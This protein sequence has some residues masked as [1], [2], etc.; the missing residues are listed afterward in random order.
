[1]PS[2]ERLARTAS[3]FRSKVVPLG[4]ARACMPPGDRPF[5][6]SRDRRDEGAYEQIRQSPLWE[7][8]WRSSGG[9]KCALVGVPWRWSVLARLAWG[10]IVSFNM[11]SKV[12]K[13]LSILRRQG[14]PIRAHLKPPERAWTVSYRCLWKK[15]PCREDIWQDQRSQ[16]HIGGWR[17]ISAARVAGQRLADKSI[18]HR[19][20]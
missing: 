14:T 9:W 11:L 6:N 20:G 18:Y 5:V 10:D 3:P 15:H 16:Q 7:D 17:A 2:H 1:M 19:Q 12:L 8:A 4:R 13:K